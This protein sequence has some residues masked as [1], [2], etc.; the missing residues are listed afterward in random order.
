LTSPSTGP[1]QPSLSDF[2]PADGARLFGGQ[3]NDGEGFAVQRHELDL[4]ARKAMHQHHRAEVAPLQAVLR[5]VSVSTTVSRCFCYFGSALGS[6]RRTSR[7]T[8]RAN[9]TAF[10]AAVRVMLT[11]DPGYRV[12]TA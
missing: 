8:R 5:Q 4:V 7:R 3:R 6:F 12:G 9:V 11:P 1:H 10:R 2:P